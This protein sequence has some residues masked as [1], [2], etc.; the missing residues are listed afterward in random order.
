MGSYGFWRI[1]IDYKVTSIFSLKKTDEKWKIID[2]YL[3]QLKI[4]SKSL[5]M[6][7]VECRYK[8]K[9]LNKVD[10]TISVDDEKY[11]FNA[12]G[13]DITEAGGFIDFGL[14]RRATKKLKKHIQ[15]CL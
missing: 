3:S 15:A 6:G 4:E 13:V 11:L 10:L 1:T 7:I 5:N 2:E 14:T 9:F 8:N 12:H